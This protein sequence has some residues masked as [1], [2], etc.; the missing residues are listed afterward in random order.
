MSLS[1]ISDELCREAVDALKAAN[2]VKAHAAKALG[3]VT[4]TFKSRIKRAAERGMLGYDPVMPGFV[5]KE[6]STK[7]GDTWVKQTREPGAEF[8][9]PPGHVTKGVSAL[10]D[11]E[12]RVTA[13]WIKTKLDPF[14]SEEMLRVIFDELKA[15]LP[16]IKA[17]KPPKHTN[18]LLLNQYTITDNHFGM[19]AWGD[20]N[21]GQ[22]YDLKIAEQL[23]IDWFSAAIAMSPDAAVGVLAQ[24]GDLLHH[25]SLESVTPAHKHVLDADSRLQKIIRVVIRMLRR[26]IGMM[27]E[28]HER[29]HVVMAS[30]NHDPAS[31]AWVR[32]LL[33]ALYEDEPRVTIDNSPDLYYVYE[34]GKTALFYHHGH[35]R[36]VKSVDSVFAGKFR[37]IFG[38]CP[39]SYGHVGHKHSDELFESNLMRV[40][41]HRTL[42]A[43]DAFASGGGWLSQR[44]AKVITYH[45][46][47]GE[48][49][50]STLSPEMVGVIE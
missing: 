21:G 44:D 32:E 10:V 33:A 25:D 24:L 22:N 20:E 50:R 48:V 23:L 27:L 38:R 3:L 13:Q 35:K 31:S 1:P 19:L 14:N 17:V 2:G 18:A 30:G 12:N 9:M 15:K 8:E 16:R 26:I 47:Y 43:P 7:I 4:E 46:E 11:S 45:K 37:E 49:F 29:V 6:A 42:A 34:H 36:D 5:V 41:R 40:E 39:K 28:K